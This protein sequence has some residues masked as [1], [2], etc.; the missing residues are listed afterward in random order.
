MW[1]DTQRHS[2]WPKLRA[3]CQRQLCLVQIVAGVATACGFDHVR[4]TPHAWLQLLQRC[5]ECSHFSAG[6]QAHPY[7]P[8]ALLLMT[9]L[10]T[11]WHA[12]TVTAGH[13][14]TTV[15]VAS[16]NEPQ[17]PLLCPS[18]SWVGVPAGCLQLMTAPALCSHLPGAAAGG[19]GAGS[20]L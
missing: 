8:S 3:A 14:P 2:I 7:T 20:V 1:Q 5:D 13:S 19:A 18:P 9:L 12:S 16:L 15:P 11:C 4:H 10:L 6:R 17:G